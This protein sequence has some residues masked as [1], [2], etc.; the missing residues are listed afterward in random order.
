[1]GKRRSSTGETGELC[2]TV[3]IDYCLV[4]FNSLLWNSELNLPWVEEGKNG[5]KTNPKVLWM[6]LH[7]ANKRANTK[8]IVILNSILSSA[9]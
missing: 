7:S 6:S 2:R 8:D 4:I 3:S 1:M 9:N 5:Q